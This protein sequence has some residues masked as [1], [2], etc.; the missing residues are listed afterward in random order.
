[1]FEVYICITE[2]HDLRLVLLAGLICLFA[3]YTTFSLLGR[4]AVAG[5]SARTSWLAAAALALGCGVWATHFVAMLAYHPHMRI[6][7]KIGLTVLSILIAIFVS[8]IG[9]AIAAGGRLRS[10]LIGGAVVGT[11]IGAMHYTGMAAMDMAARIDYDPSMVVASLLIGIALTCVATGIG[12][13]RFDISRRLAATLVLTLAICSLHFT[14]MSAT[15]FVADPSLVDMSGSFEPSLLA[16]AIAAITV[17]VLALS[18]GGAVVDQ[19]LATRAENE[20]ER[21]RVSE[22]RFRQLAEATFEGILIHI[23][24]IVIDANEALCR[25]VGRPLEKLVGRSVLEFINV[26]NQ[27]SPT[28]RPANSDDAATELELM[29]GDGSRIAV[30]ILGQSIDH[31]GK[32]ARVVAVRDIRE[33]KKAEE[34]IRHMAHHD[35]LTGLPNRVLFHDRLAQALALAQRNGSTVAVLCLDLD[36]F[37]NV[38]DLLGHGGGDVLLQRVATR[39]LDNVRAHDTVARLSGDEFAI[40]Q[41]GV[42][43][44]DGAATLAE[45]LVG[46]VGLPFELD[47]QQMMIGTSIGVA[48]YPGDGDTGEDL[49][50][51]ADTALYR[52]K[53][54]GRHTFRF[55]EASMDLLLQERS[56]LER[57]LRQAL[58]NHSELEVHYQPLIDCDGKGVMGFEALLRWNH[59][60]RGP[61]SP[62]EFIPLAEDCGLILPLGNWVLGTACRDA[63]KWPENMRVAVNLSPAQFRHADLAGEVLA[64]LQESGLA[65]E[66]LELE[67]TEGVLIADTDRTLSTLNTLKQAGVHISLDDF[68]TGYSSLSYLQRFPFDKIKIDRSFV[69]EMERN[70]DSMAI[71]RAVI[72]LG[73]SLRITV[74]AEGVETENQLALLQNENCDQVQ[75]YLLGR[76]LPSKEIAPLLLSGAKRFTA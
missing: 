3:T 29:H 13:M 50:R 9:L 24:G 1:M 67:I 21:L 52:A 62:V 30:E 69:W 45:R 25:L 12:C 39:L 37:K 64:T 74:T 54:A 49:I 10:A 7:Y 43:H 14:G 66:R 56:Q 51:A 32:Q 4:A 61:I 38:N 11:G 72:A 17:L 40:I 22:A 58:A 26:S 42:P 70:A 63:V 55:F 68:G 48:L 6:N 8:G 36:R 46:S 53:E 73:H 16:I 5:S 60:Q 35:M 71:V 18:L 20:K 57:D 27:D 47:G 34:R 65:A 28:A 33:R 15:Q 19:H 44:P 75:G 23:D 59:P 31:D 76:P 2:Q 41:T